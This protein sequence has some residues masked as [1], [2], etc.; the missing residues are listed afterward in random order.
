MSEDGNKVCP[1]CGEEIKAVA[2]KCRY[3]QSFLT[4]QT[5]VDQ[6]QVEPG[7]KKVKKGKWILIPAL[8]ILA[9]LALYIFNLIDGPPGTLIDIS[10]PDDETVSLLSQADSTD[11]SESTQDQTESDDATNTLP[12]QTGDSAAA[13]SPDTASESPSV[14]VNTIIG[15]AEPV[16]IPV[17]A[18]VGLAETTPKSSVEVF[19][20]EPLGN[21]PGNT[22]N[23]GLAALR[24]GWVYYANLNDSG[25][26]YKVKNDGTGR[27]AL[28]SDRSRFINVIGSWIYYMNDSDGKKIYKI[29]TDGT[30]RQR[31]NNDRSEYLNVSGD[32]IY[33][34]NFND[35]KKI[36]KIRTDGSGR[37]KVNDNFSAYLNVIGDW[38]YF[39][40]IDD[41]YRIYKVRTDGT[42]QTRL[43]LIFGVEDLIVNGDWLYFIVRENRQIFKTNVDETVFSRVSDDSVL[44]YNLAGDWVYYVNQDDGGSIYKI[45][46]DK[47]GRQKVGITGGV[48]FLNLIDDWIYYKHFERLKRIN[49]NNT[50]LDEVVN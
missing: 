12:A 22:I 26:I 33:Y 13:Q 19:L 43:T 38:I 16:D 6:V 47:S 40:N 24:D 18:L 44:D 29:S 2:V 14:P 4:T 17:P 27:V 49:L 41:G 20:A 45:R 35:G 42:Q 31:L 9:L 28:N 3:C 5:A 1:Y 15:L 21:S 48:S 25:K 46:T 7:R 36:Y 39:A 50:A 34:M 30:G 23:L 8:L 11:A 32:W 37:T 10:K